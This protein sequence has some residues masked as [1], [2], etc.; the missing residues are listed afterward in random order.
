[1]G[2]HRGW[3]EWLLS[4]QEPVEEQLDS[5]TIDITNETKPRR[6]SFNP[7][8]RPDPPDPPWNDDWDG[9]AP[10]PPVP[11]APDG[12]DTGSPTLSTA[13]HSSAQTFTTN[14]SATV[15][16]G[17]WAQALFD[18]RLPTNEFATNLGP[19][20]CQGTPDRGLVDRLRQH[21]F[22]EV[23]KFIFRESSLTARFYWRP[24]DHRS[25]LLISTVDPLGQQVR[26]C[27]SLT[28]LKLIRHGN[29]LQSYRIAS[30]GRKLVP[31]GTFSFPI[32]E[33]LILFYCVFA[34]MKNQDHQHRPT[35]ALRDWP[36]K[37]PSQQQEQDEEQIFGAPIEDRDYIHALRVY[38]DRD[39]GAS[40]LETRPHAGPM[41]CC[42][43]WTAFIT[44]HVQLSG[45]ARKVSSK[46]VQ[47]GI[48][49]LY[50]FCD[51]HIPVKGRNG[52]AHLT[53]RKGSDAD[54]FMSAVNWLRR[55][56][57]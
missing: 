36:H 25:R 33:K 19:T 55:R 46:V 21:N 45:W 2:R 31:W 29:Q 18:Q 6:N 15:V 56:R 32:Y 43:I 10:R 37:P 49:R 11:D 5:L 57:P 12:F 52:E 48:L 20:M 24:P 40:R 22:Y 34:A 4:K 14:S 53:F 13:T 23:A 50:V 38:F 7:Y 16:N 27:I 41:K 17:H 30:D 1:M 54:E 3:I 51:G 9:T 42:P 26:I 39:S 47:L 8:F 44:D 28:D 35:T